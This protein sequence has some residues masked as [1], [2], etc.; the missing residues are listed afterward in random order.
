M[1]SRPVDESVVNVVVR[2]PI[3]L[4]SKTKQAAESDDLSLS[5]LVRRAVRQYLDAAKGLD[6]EDQ[7][8]RATA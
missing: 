2:F 1:P 5:Q 6:A 8:E 3:D 7:V 4:H